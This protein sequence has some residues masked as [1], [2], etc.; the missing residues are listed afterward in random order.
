MKKLSLIVL[1]AVLSAAALTGCSD[2][3]ESS[4]TTTEE[5]TEYTTVKP[6]VATT[7]APTTLA[8]TTAAPTTLAPTTVEPTTE[9]PTEKPTEAPKSEVWASGQFKVG[10]DIPAGRYVLYNNVSRSA[11]YCISS[12]SNGDDIIAN[13][14]FNNQ[15]YIDILDGQYL[16]LSRCEALPF[17]KK[18]EVDKSKGY[19]EEGQYLIGVDLPAGEYKLEMIA[20]KRSA[21]YCIS[22]DANTDNIISND[23]FEGNSYVT[24]SDGQFLEINRCKLYF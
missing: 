8:P 5:I 17:D 4:K 11:Y 24:V 23:N 7:A 16:K 18:K 13:N 19:L 6:T 22:S 15:N 1:A 10:V 21:Y 14:N 9:K 2:S 20:G 12:D 3:K